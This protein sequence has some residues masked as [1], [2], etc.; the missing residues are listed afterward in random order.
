M[1]AVV[2]VLLSVGLVLL[3]LFAVDRQLCVSGLRQDLSAYLDNAEEVVRIADDPRV[4]IH[5]KAVVFAVSNIYNSYFSAR[6]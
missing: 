3:V 2:T 1:G 6:N 5:Y 4:V